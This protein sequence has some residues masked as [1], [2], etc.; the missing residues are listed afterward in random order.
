M[1][2]LDAAGHVVCGALVAAVEHQEALVELGVPARE[3]VEVGAVGRECVASG[4]DDKAVGVVGV[5]K[6]VQEHVSGG[7]RGAE[8]AELEHE[9]DLG[10]ELFKTTQGFELVALEVCNGDVVA[11]ELDSGD[12]L[13]HDARV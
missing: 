8:V 9:V 2:P 6:L 4:V 7:K 1:V 12:E 3:A 13:G 10:L 11:R 5:E